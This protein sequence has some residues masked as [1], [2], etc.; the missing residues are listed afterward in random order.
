MVKPGSPGIVRPLARSDILPIAALL[1]L[2]SAAFVHLTAMP[3]FEDEGSQLR[4]I[5]RAIE[6]GEWLLPMDEGKPLE[7]WPMVPLVRLGFVPPL[8][9]TRG[10]HVLAG[11]IAAVLTW[12]LALGVLE[13]RPAALASGVLFAICPFAV[14]LQRLALSD[15]FL[16]AAGTWVLVNSLAL[17]RSPTW[18][19]AAAS[20]VSL[21]LAAFCKMPI[22]FVFLASVPFALLLMPTPERQRM[23]LQPRA[24]AKLLMAHAPVVVL[25]LVVVVTAV[26]RWRHGHSPGFGLRDLAGIG[27]GNNQDMGAGAGVSR[28]NLIVELTAQLSWPVTVI[29]MI[30]VCAGAIFGDWRVRWLVTAG[31]LPMLGIG[32]LVHFWYSRYLLFTLPPLIVAAVSGWQALAVRAR[33]LRSTPVEVAV[34]LVCVGFMG[35]QSTRL[36]LD[37]VTA[38]WSPL[39]RFQYFEG[40]GSGYGFPEAAR[41]VLTASD[42]PRLIYALDGHSAYQLRNYLPPT[43]NS[44]IEPIY[45][46]DDGRFLRTDE[47]RLQNLLEHTP[48]WIVIPVQLLDGYLD[49]TFHRHDLSSILDLQRIATFDKPG[50]HVQLAL[51]RVTRH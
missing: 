9:V 50:A 38:R 13:R 8:V 47:A 2:G 46:A 33:P 6:A 44:R 18:T 30:G 17:V 15:M 31:L 19:R 23:L 28:P 16:C 21:V 27:L 41:F 34:L 3:A 32:L 10:L 14:Y 51:Y 26:I 49:S 22:G 4:W 5:W 29:A 45:Y 12:R 24:I 42:P 37:P 25:G 36:I 1:L 20:G 7:A 35:W 39:D 11:M 43:W 40:W 48:A